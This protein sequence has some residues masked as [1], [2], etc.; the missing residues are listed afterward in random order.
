VANYVI[1]I[2][3]TDTDEPVIVDLAGMDRNKAED[4]T[5][6]L[7]YDLAEAKSINAPAVEVRTDVPGSKL[8]LEPARIRAIDLIE[9]DDPPPTAE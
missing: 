6:K 7:H 1:K 4:A 5:A 2:Q 8:V 9:V 3:Y